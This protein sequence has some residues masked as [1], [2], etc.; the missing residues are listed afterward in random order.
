MVVNEFLVTV[1]C[2]SLYRLVIG[3]KWMWNL[4]SGNLRIYEGLYL[5]KSHET[6]LVKATIA[7]VM[8]TSLNHRAYSLNIDRP[9]TSA[10]P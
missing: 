1:L 2:T 9:P 7:I 4:R 5:T 6:A 10:V 3:K 8:I